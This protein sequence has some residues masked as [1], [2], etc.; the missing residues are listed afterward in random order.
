LSATV[1]LPAQ[2]PISVNSF[3]ADVSTA[4][5]GAA[6]NLTWDVTGAD[7]ITIARVGREGTEFLAEVI[8][9][10]LP[11]SG[12]VEYTLPEATDAGQFG[13]SV[14]FLLT[15]EDATSARRSAYVR[16]PLAG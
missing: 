1:E 7:N 4:T 10:A 9:E 12:S 15:A 14:T 6:I 13:S 3:A 11:A 5:P 2:M 8:G 16:L